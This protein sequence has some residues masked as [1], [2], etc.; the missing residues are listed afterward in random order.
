MYN[1]KIIKKAY[2]KLVLKKL[3]KYLPTI[4]KLDPKNLPKILDEIK[5]INNLNQENLS[6]FIQVLLLEKSKIHLKNPKS[7]EIILDFARKN[8]LLGLQFPYL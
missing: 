3:E 4:L 5:E 6:D 2:N 8:K 7:K 1:T